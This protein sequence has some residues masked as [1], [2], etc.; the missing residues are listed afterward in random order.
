MEEKKRMFKLRNGAIL[1]GTTESFP[2]F[3]F[4]GD[5]QDQEDKEIFF[6][7]GEFM[8]LWE[9]EE[10]LPTGG[11][12]GPDYDIVEELFDEGGKK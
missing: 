10:G 3:M 6:E 1:K 7:D 4:V 8:Y 12:F 11:A 9:E 2:R 5:F